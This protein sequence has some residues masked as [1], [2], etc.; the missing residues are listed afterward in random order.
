MPGLV[1]LILL[2]N[3][4]QTALSMRALD[5]EM[6]SMKVLP[7]SFAAALVLA[8]PAACSRASSWRCRRCTL[9]W[10]APGCG[11]FDPPAAGYLYVAP[12][13]VVAGLML[14]AIGLLVSSVVE[15]LENFAGGMRT[16]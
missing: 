7:R 9:S 2:F 4:M 8:D 15:Q 10:P 12:A 13:I 11:G 5:H 14:G 3:G 1:G 16:S 6:G